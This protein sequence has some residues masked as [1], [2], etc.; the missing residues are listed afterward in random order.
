MLR[1]ISLK[2]LTTFQCLYQTSLF[3][4]KTHFLCVSYI[5]EKYCFLHAQ[6][7]EDFDIVLTYNE[8]G[9]LDIVLGVLLKSCDL[10]NPYL[11]HRDFLNQF[12]TFKH[13]FKSFYLFCIYTT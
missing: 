13:F 4:I 3:G 6:T 9:T 10:A 5:I 2:G 7:E 1:N 12:F 11:N 8:L